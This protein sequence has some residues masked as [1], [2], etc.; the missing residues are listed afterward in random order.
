MEAIQIIGG[1][2]DE[3]D[4]HV[5]VAAGIHAGSNKHAVRLRAAGPIRAGWRG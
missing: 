1:H 5:R 3:K 2:D 4:V